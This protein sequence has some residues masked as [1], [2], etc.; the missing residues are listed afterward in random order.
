MAGLL[1]GLCVL[2]RAAVTTFHDDRSSVAKAY[3][4]SARIIVVALEMALPGVV[5]HWIDLRL[6]TVVLFLLVGL[7][8]GCTGGVWHLIQMT[9]VDARRESDQHKPSDGNPRSE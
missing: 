1:P 4:W 5:G 3:H 6:G 8:I 2:P 7:I 9:R